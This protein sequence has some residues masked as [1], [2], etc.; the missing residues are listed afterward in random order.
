MTFYAKDFEELTNAQV[1]EILKSRSQIF[2]LEQNIHCLDMDDVD[3]RSRHYF[4]EEEG[5]IVAYL[6]TFYK[7]K[8]H[9]VAKIGRVL[10]LT[11]RKGLGA[12]LMRYAMAD[13]KKQMKCERVC[14][15]A[16]KQAVG[17]YEKCGFTAV[18]G[19]FME[20]GIPHIAMEMEI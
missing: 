13:I 19:E 16:Q 10:T 20:E 18:S 7:D 6:R 4:M 5:R 9:K 14:V 1:Y 8:N 11:H 2:M 15:D 3:Y 12:E 17:F